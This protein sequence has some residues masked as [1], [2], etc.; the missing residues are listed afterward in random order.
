MKPGE[1]L[2]CEAPFRESSSEAAFI[3]IGDDGQPFVHDSG[4]STTYRLA[5]PGDDI[6]TEFND[7]YMVVNE[8]GR[9]VVYECMHDAVL[10]RQVYVTFSFEDFKKLHLNRMVPV[11]YKSNGEPKWMDGGSYWL[12][13]R[14]RRQYPGGVVFDPAGR[15]DRAD[16]LNLWQGFAVEARPGG[17]W[18]KLRDHILTIIC[19]GNLEH[20]DYL[21]GWLARLVQY[22]AQQGEVAVVLRGAE[23]TGKGTLANAIRHLFG[24]HGLAVN[25]SEHLVGR[26][27]GHLRDVVF[28][29]ADE[30]F[31]AGNKAHIGALKSLITEPRLPIEAK[32]KNPIEAPNFIHLMMASNEEW[33]VPASVDSRRFFVLDV[34]S[35]R[36]ND[37]AYFAAIWAELDDGGYEAMLHDL[38]THDLTGFNVRRVPQTAALNEQ[39]LL[40]LDAHTAW[41]KDVLHEGHVVSAYHSEWDGFEAIE[42]LYESYSAYARSRHEYRPLDRAQLKTF[43]CK[44]GGRKKRPHK[45]RRGY[46]FGTLA[47]A[48]EVFCRKTGLKIDWPD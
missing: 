2:R 17:S 29:F 1:K 42:T 47:R 41:W 30:A 38:L 18:A 10:D 27:N 11:G 37:H 9:T 14:D 24:P 45:Q 36:A 22:P 26:F 33:V 28:L 5:A 7:R 25:S 8:A 3:R 48:R 40:S 4:N 19:D 32:Y 12:K 46:Y 21:I 35:A 16:V 44:M 34:S 13:H 39:R 23:G 6:V 20:F 31:Y 15:G 43:L